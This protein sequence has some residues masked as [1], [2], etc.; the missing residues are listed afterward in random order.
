M[1]HT[2][3]PIPE[4]FTSVTPKVD[5]RY[6]DGMEPRRPSKIPK[7]TWGSSPKQS[8]R[9]DRKGAASGKPGP[10]AA[11][12]AI[13]AR[14]NVLFPDAGEQIAWMETLHP[15]FAMSPLELIQSGRE[16]QLLVHLEAWI[17]EEGL[18]GTSAGQ[19]R[20]DPQA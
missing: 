10:E 11:L 5:A 1:A 6:A 12:P 2:V 9:K 20:T 18:S 17:R 4:G 13:Q 19:P 3:R 16:G 7:K 15:L 14:L 8:K